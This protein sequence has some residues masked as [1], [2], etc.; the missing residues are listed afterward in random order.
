MV[1]LMVNAFFLAVALG[2]G[3]MVLPLAS[4]LAQAPPAAAPTKPDAQPPAGAKPSAAPNG[5]KAE[6]LGDAQGW[7]AF[8]D[9][10]KS[11]R[12]CYLVGRPLKSEPDNL[13]RG[14]VYVYVTHRPSEKSYNVV[15]FAVGY[16]YKDASDAELAVDTRKFTLFTNKESAWA[17]DAATEKAVVEAMAKGKQAVL[18]G[19]S[20]RGTGTA[21][22]YALDGFAPMLAQIDKACGVKR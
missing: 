13:K 2:G 14:D 16:P 5:A 6:R 18:K 20:A 4:T 1:R 10:D 12:V 7:S 22:T 8:V 9:T 15:N 3:A 21:D 17:R 19:T 11:A